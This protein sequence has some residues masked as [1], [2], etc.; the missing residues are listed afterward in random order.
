[1]SLSSVTPPL[2]LTRAGRAFCGVIGSKDRREYTVRLRWL[3]LMYTFA[4]CSAPRFDENYLLTQQVIG[5]MVNLAARLMAAAGPSE[6]LVDD[7]TR[8]QT[9]AFFNFEVCLVTSPLAVTR[10]VSG[11]RAKISVSL[12]RRPL[13]AQTRP[14]MLLKGKSQPTAIFKP[15]SVRQ[16]TKSVKVDLSLQSRAP[17]RRVVC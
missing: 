7:S 12:F 1:V 17:V 13:S 6:V 10:F 16:K 9:A 15:V 11:T 2:G 8:A 3:K 5:D 14:S 4:L